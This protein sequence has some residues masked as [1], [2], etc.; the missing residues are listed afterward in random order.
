MTIKELYD[1]VAQL[2]FETSLEDYEEGF[3]ALVN[4]AIIQVNRV[5]PKMAIFKLNHFPLAN[6]LEKEYFE[7]MCKDEEA[8]TFTCDKARSYYFECNGNGVVNIEKSTDSGESWEVIGTVDLTAD[9]GRFT[10]YRGFIRDGGEPYLGLVRL[11]FDGDFIYYVRN[12]AL[13]GSLI[14]DDEADIP[15]YGKYSAY[16][17]ASLTD[18]FD[19]FVCPPISD[20]KR[21][22]K[23]VLDEDYFVENVSTLL[24][25]ASLKGVYDVYYYRKIKTIDSSMDIE[26]TELDL[27]PDMCSILVNLVASYVWVDDEPTKSEYY[28]NL[29]REQVA[30]IMSREKHFNPL[31]YRNRNGW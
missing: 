11:K 29:Y 1:S 22:G 15:V 21:G 19:S 8:L 6:R 13:Y 5:R 7:P 23:F 20:A 4:R 26:T 9:H 28:L 12:V 3:F 18:D 16:D 2:G 30:E 24:V 14:S 31:V 10:A 27:D 25:P 17:L